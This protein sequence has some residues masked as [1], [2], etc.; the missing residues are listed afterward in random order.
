VVATSPIRLISVDLAFNRILIDQQ[1]MEVDRMKKLLASLVVAILVA[2]AV[3]PY[4]TAYAFPGGTWVSGV[5]VANLESTTATVHIDFYTSL[6]AVALS[7]DGGTI[8]GNSAKTWYLPSA[9]SSLPSPFIGSAVVSS[10]KQIAAI[11]NTQLPSGTNPQRVGTST[12]VSTAQAAPTMYATQLLKAAGGW[13]SYCAVQNT[14]S[15]SASVTGSYYN[16]S[17]TMVYSR[18]A[19][20]PGYAS[21]LFDQQT[22]TGLTAGQQYSAKFVSDAAHPL[23]VVC[24]F[25]NAGA[26]A[27]AGADMQFHSYNGMGTG[28][29]KLFLPRVVKNYYNYQSGLKVQNVGTAAL[30]VKV[31]YNFGGTSYEQTSPSFG[32]GQSWG[33]YM[34]S[35]AQLPAA[36]AAVSGSGSAVVEVVSPTAAKLIIATVNE[37]N[38]VSP[39]GRGVTYEGA[40]AT[41][42]KSTLVFPQVTSEY[43]GYSSGI[44]VQKVE[45]GTSNCTVNFSA[46]GAV[47]AFQQVPSVTLTDASPSYSLF[48]PS[49]SGMVA[50]IANDNYNGAVTVN[51]TGAKIVGI[52]NLS[53]RYDR[54]PRYGNVLGDTFTTYRGMG[55]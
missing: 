37:D 9:I 2:V 6:G 17:G 44:Q 4:G 35:P 24:N 50:G 40:L 16:A 32:P 23:A 41:D 20:I 42:G 3:V 33:P 30:A 54:D 12:G 55:Q 8:G 19:S 39:S 15:S 22:E 5:T 26:D 46:S 29:Q 52:A 27:T 18:V 13:N 21:A 1:K 47:G 49:A 7:F 34:G 38:R 45:A 11:V 10:D 36:M 48:A 28:A 31:T 25:Y 43:Y 51:C 14:A 53:F